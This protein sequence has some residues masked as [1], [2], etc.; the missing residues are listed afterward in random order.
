MT[1]FEWSQITRGPKKPLLMLG[2]PPRE[3]VID[4]N[5]V[6]TSPDVKDEL[7]GISD[8]AFARLREFEMLPY[9]ETQIIEGDQYFVGSLASILGLDIDGLKNASGVELPLDDVGPDVTALTTAIARARATDA[10]LTLAEVEAGKF[11]FY[12]VVVQD[13]EGVDIAFVR[14]TTGLKV[15]TANKFFMRFADKM[16]KLEDPIFRIDYHFDFAVRGD[17]VAI[18]NVDNFLA[19]F[20]DQDALKK[21][22]PSFVQELNSNLGIQLSESTMTSMKDAGDHGSRFAQQIRR[23]SRLSYLRE[24]EQA[25]LASYLED[26]SAIGHG[27]R[28]E[29]GEVHV[30]DEAI[31]SFLHLLEQRLWKGHFDGTVR[32]AQAFAAM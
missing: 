22:V 3:G 25:S 9:S 24:I 15:A 21:A 20:G 12:V 32:R 14:K 6:D 16:A 4:A 19:L 27:I 11:V 23:V 30:P 5:R 18:W 31:G 10:R 1:K 17:D 13:S 8:V 2:N 29:G 26:V 28:V 7:A